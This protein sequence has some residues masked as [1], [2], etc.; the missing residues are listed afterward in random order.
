[1]EKL[2]ADYFAF[3]HKYVPFYLKHWTLQTKCNFCYFLRSRLF[4]TDKFFRY[5]RE[6]SV[7]NQGRS[8]GWPEIRTLKLDLQG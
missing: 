3:S 2:K 4:S 7:A 8:L 6:L 5:N 1:M